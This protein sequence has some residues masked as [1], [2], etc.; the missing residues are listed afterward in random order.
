MSVQPTRLAL[1]TALAVVALLGAA[2][3]AGQPAATTAPTGTAGASATAGAA[4]PSTGTGGTSTPSGASG[5]SADQAAQAHQAALGLV[6][7]G[8]LGGEKGTTD[9]LRTLAGRVTSEGRAL[10]EQIR[11]L[12]TAQGLTLSD[13]VGAQIQGVLNDLQAPQR[14]AVRPG[15]A[16]GGRRPRRAGPG[17]GERRAVVAGRLGRGQGRRP[18]RA[19]APRRAGRCRIRDAA[20]PRARARRTSVNAGYGRPGR[21]GPGAARRAGRAGR[22]AA[23]RRGAPAAPPCVDPA[24]GWSES[25]VGCISAPDAPFAPCGG[26]PT[27][28]HPGAVVWGTASGGVACIVRGRIAGRRATRPGGGRRG[29]AGGRAGVGRGVRVGRW[30]Y[31]IRR[32]RRRRRAG[33][34]ARCTDRPHR[35]GCAAAGERCPSR[36]R[37]P[38]AARRPGHPDRH[39]ARR[40]G[41]R[42]R[43]ALHRRLVVPGA[44]A[45]AA[46]GTTVLVGHV[47]SAASGL[48]VFAVLRDVA[49]GERVLLRGADGRTARLPGDGRRQARQGRAPRRPV[50]PRRAAPPRAGHMRRPVRPGD[51]AL[52]RQRRRLRGAG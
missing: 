27:A 32:R 18:G 8:G 44:L 22:R 45:G 10:D 20:A 2:C 11:T 50:R 28:P 13:D 46:S 31:A 7:L 37:C 5:L 24:G 41:H 47:D 17:R 9:A 39:R 33:R 1:A 48:G 12:A 3:S 23:R 51:P 25:G 6:A 52:H 35:C 40:R 43:P 21:G 36:S 49:V 26:R 19:G 34:G 16:A 30:S 29:G 15:V 4:A 14:P 42:P 38:A